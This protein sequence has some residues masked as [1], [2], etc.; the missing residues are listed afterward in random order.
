MNVPFLDLSPTHASIKAE[1]LSTFEQVYDQNVF[2]L[3]EQL[4]LFEEEYAGF[5]H[6]EFAVGTSNGLDALYLSLKVLQIGPGDEVIVPSNTFIATLLAVSA[7]GARPVLVEPD[8]QTYNIDP[9]CI[10]AAITASTKAIIPVHL[11]GQASDMGRISVIAQKHSLMLLEDNAQAHGASFNGK[12]TGSW[13]DINATSFYPGKNLGAL[14]DG[15]AITTNHE[16]YAELAN[17]LRNYGSKVKYLHEYAGHNMRLDELQAAFLRVKL[18]HLDQWTFERQN[19]A[20]TYQQMLKGTGDLILPYTHPAAT[21]VYHLY[22]IRTKYRDALQEYLAKHNVGSL[23]HYP[24]PPHLQKAY[25][26]SGFYPGQFPIAEEISGT[27][28]SLPIWPG[29]LQ[30]QLEKV[31]FTVMSFFKGD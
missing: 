19:I 10:E 11:Y 21:H 30:E 27:C 17:H 3:G 18:T 29:M 24:V 13:G 6:T 16:E 14:G 8:I 7:T 31:I 28:L 12:L 26:H 4:K 22:V 2:I 5:N 9:G 25:G 20:S 23:I 15:G 1:M